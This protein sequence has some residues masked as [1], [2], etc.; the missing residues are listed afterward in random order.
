MF[1]NSDLDIENNLSSKTSP[2][3]EL[4][5]YVD[6]IVQGLLNENDEVLQK[7]MKYSELLTEYLSRYGRTTEDD[8]S[9]L[10]LRDFEISDDIDKKIEI[11][12]DALA[13][14][15]T[16]EE[17]QHYPEIQEGYGDEGHFFK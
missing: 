8:Y 10:V 3:E 13:K 17:S 5:D 9:D 4:S 6:S 16:L 2:R 15:I 1:N 7:K 12:K 14:G 11:L